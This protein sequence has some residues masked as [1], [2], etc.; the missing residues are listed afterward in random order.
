MSDLPLRSP[1]VGVQW[2]RR[3]VL[4]GCGS[5]LLPFGCEKTDERSL[6]RAGEHAAHLAE[7]T[8]EDVQEIRRGLPEGAEKLAELWREGKPLDEPSSARTALRL[9]RRK[10]QDLRVAKSTFFAIAVAG[11]VVRNDREQDEMAGVSLYAAFPALQGFEGRYAE[12]L[13]ALKEADGVRGKPDAQWVAAARVPAPSDLD[14]PRSDCLYVTGWAWSSYAYRLEFTLRSEVKLAL[15]GSQENVP[16][17]YCFVLVGGGVYSAPE[18][19]EVNAQAIAKLG[20]LRQLDAR[21]T[22]RHLMEVEG[23]RFAL[24]VHRAPNFPADVAVAVMRSE[25]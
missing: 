17:L 8:S 18:A 13:G 1:R 23:R 21:G 6:E 14:P 5:I 24:G 20:P 3:Q 12:A 9:T 15:R 4:S 2:S 11:V 16:L 22:Y 10:V 7:L 19:P 25:T